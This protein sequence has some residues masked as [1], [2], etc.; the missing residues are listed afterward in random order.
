MSSLNR[1]TLIGNL[2]RDPEIRSTQNGNEVC[3]IGLATNET[4]KDRNTGERRERTEYHRAVV[5]DKNLIDLSRR[6]LRRGSK[7][8]LEGQLQTRSWNDKNG[9]ERRVTEIVLQ[10]FSGRI[11]FLD[12][13]DAGEHQADAQTDDQAQAAID[14]E[15]PF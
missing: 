4:W 10:G 11:V 1:A 2:T 14:D 9:V 6:F 13:R 5:F 7:V 15:I 8:L 3:N 12:R